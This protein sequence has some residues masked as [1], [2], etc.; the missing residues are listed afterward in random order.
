MLND[1]IDIEQIL[2]DLDFS[3]GQTTISQF[4]EQETVVSMGNQ[5]QIIGGTSPSLE[6][7]YQ[8][9]SRMETLKSIGE[10]LNTPVIGKSQ[11]FFPIYYI[12]KNL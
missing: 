11:K 12:F 2:N 5:Q 10:Q 9:P 1:Q 8:T 4:Y 6:M 3:I 7:A